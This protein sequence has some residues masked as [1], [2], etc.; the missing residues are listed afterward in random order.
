M[1][2][3]DKS[4]AHRFTIITLLMWGVV[5]SLVGC[6]GEDEESQ[7]AQSKL[8]GC[9]LISGGTMRG[10]GGGQTERCTSECVLSSNCMTLD[11]AVCGDGSSAAYDEFWNCVT[12]CEDAL[13]KH[14]C[15]PGDAEVGGSAV[16][17]GYTDC[18]DGSDE[19]NCNQDKFSCDSGYMIPEIWVCDLASD[20]ADGSDEGPECAK[21]QCD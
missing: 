2:L 16:C 13:P 3:L 14:K 8:Q 20:C 19:A 21:I 15:G 10:L 5:I 7:S 11:E 1:R 17:D 4:K 18:Q 6:G 9:G 12:Q